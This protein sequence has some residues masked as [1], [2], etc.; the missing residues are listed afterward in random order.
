LIKR[1]NIPHFENGAPLLKANIVVDTGPPPPLKDK[2]ND[3]KSHPIS[4]FLNLPYTA[5]FL[6]N[7]HY[8]E[9]DALYTISGLHENPVFQSSM[10]DFFFTETWTTC[11]SR[12]SKWFL[13]FGFAS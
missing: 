12:T 1:V 13:L 8:I 4:R 3:R 2:L 6:Q 10:E 11:L 5:Q 9:N 7:L